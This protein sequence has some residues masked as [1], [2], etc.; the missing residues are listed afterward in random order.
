MIVG[1]TASNA[2]KIKTDGTTRAVNCACCGCSYDFPN[3]LCVDG[4][5]MSKVA[6]CGWAGGGLSPSKNWQI[7]LYKP[8]YDSSGVEF[9][10]PPDPTKFVW[11]LSGYY[12][13]TSGP[14]QGVRF[15]W[16][17]SDSVFTGEW[18]NYDWGPPLNFGCTKPI[19]TPTEGGCPT[20]PCDTPPSITVP[21]CTTDGPNSGGFC[22]GGC[23]YYFDST[24]CWE[25]GCGGWHKVPPEYC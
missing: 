14:C 9:L 23:W 10:P 5:T 21:T 3:G 18:K 1:R 17:N 19:P 2:I 13:E 4:L 11:R 7:N 20:D 6:P 8:P 22:S 25:H 16:K 15:F 24:C 12:G